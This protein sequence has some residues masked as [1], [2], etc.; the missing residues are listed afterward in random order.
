MNEPRHIERS[1]ISQDPS[2]LHSSGMTGCPCCVSRNLVEA[3]LM[4]VLTWAYSR[5]DQSISNP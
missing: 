2:S 5:R 3:P 4:V 1:E